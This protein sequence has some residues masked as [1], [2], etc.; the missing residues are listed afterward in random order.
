M[1]IAGF[2]SSFNVTLFQ[3]LKYHATAIHPFQNSTAII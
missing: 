1:L 3:K 2:E